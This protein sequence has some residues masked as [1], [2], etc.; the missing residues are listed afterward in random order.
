MA[1]PPAWAAWAFF[2]AGWVLVYLGHGF[3][4]VM[5]VVVFT[6]L[7]LTAYERKRDSVT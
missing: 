1:L 3:W 2:V 4:G 7:R 6:A 5:F